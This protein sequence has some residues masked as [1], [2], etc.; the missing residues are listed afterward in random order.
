MTTGLIEGWQHFADDLRGDNPLLAPTVWVDAL[1]VAGFDA[2]Q[3]WPKAGSPGEALG[4]HVIVARV[5]GE[6][7]G[8]GT[9]AQADDADA[10]VSVS[11][12][13]APADVRGLWRVRFD[14]ALPVERLDLLRELARQQVMHVLRL[15]P[16]SPPA[17]HDRL[18]DLG[19]DSLMAVQL[20]N[21]LGRALDLKRALPSTLMFDHPTI[22]AIAVHLLERLADAVPAPSAT[23]PASATTASEPLAALAIAELSDEDIARLLDERLEAK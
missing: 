4:Q 2:A 19:M 17:L 15:D 23:A 1:R 20:R 18:M 8:S 13:E 11:T 3:A 9:S 16:S 12:A 6:A 14:A 22:A 21:G 7:Q 10:S 5:A